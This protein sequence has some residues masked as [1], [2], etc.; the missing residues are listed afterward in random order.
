MS[1]VLVVD[2]ESAISDVIADI[3]AGDGH[4]VE[5]AHDGR[6][7]LERFD[8]R[9]PDVVLLDMMMPVLDGLATLDELRRRDARGVRVILMSAGRRPD[10]ALL[11]E[12]DVRFLRKPFELEE[13]LAIVSD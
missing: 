10:D 5:V 2:D 12:H 9:T 11:D 6:E 4:E 1:R 7:A 8:A 13:L 3:L